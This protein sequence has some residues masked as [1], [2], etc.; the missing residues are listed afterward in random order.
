MKAILFT[1]IDSFNKKSQYVV[2]CKAENVNAIVE[3]EKKLN[4]E[5]VSHECLSV[6]ITE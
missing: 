4:T 1:C 2:V 6:I 3:Q 5:I